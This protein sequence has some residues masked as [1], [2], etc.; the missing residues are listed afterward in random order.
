M[1]GNEASLSTNAILGL[2]RPLGCKTH[3]TLR[4]TLE[5][6]CNYAP[7]FHSA[8]RKD[9]W[10]PVEISEATLRFF[11]ANTSKFLLKKPGFFVLPFRNTHCH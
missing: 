2:G 7:I 6:S 8:K 5:Q 3:S 4:A 1:K 11:F 9:E 10:K